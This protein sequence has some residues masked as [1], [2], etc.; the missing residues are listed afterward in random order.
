MHSGPLRSG[1][2]EKRRSDVIA[3]ERRFALHGVR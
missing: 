2:L 3:H 1:K